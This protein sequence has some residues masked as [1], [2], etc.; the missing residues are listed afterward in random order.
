MLARLVTSLDPARVETIVISVSEPGPIGDYLE[1]QGV[2]V[3]A[4][5]LRQGVPDVRTPFRVVR[6]LRRWRADL[7][8]TWLYH[9]DIVGGMAGWASRIP[10][11]WNVRQTD[12]SP[13]TTRLITR[14]AA[15]AAAQW[16]SWLAR[17]I[18]CVSYATR[19]AHAAIGYDAAKME[20][21]PNGFDLDVCKPDDAARRTVRREFGLPAS[22]T[23][24]GHV[25]RY[26]PA[27]DHATM[28]RAAAALPPSVH[29]MMVGTG[30]TPDNRE[31]AAMR[32]ALG[33]EQRV[34]LIG[35]RSDVP[36]LT[37]AFDVAV[38]SSISEGFSNAIGEA[39]A[40]GVPCVVTDVGDSAR[41][42][43]D[44]GRVVQAGD[45]AQLAGAIGDLLA[46]P[47]AQRQRLGRRARERI[48]DRYGLDVITA[49]Y[50]ALW[51][52]VC[53]VAH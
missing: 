46:L 20:V 41:I 39:M 26:D 5:G 38:S 52:R 16:S 36:R 15:H 24:V 31:L 22:A 25:G 12:L 33:L 27:K 40:C 34:H 48:E 7:L 53:A 49:R 9:A 32:S 42:V 8:Q 30:V 51:R 43:G 1:S 18:V 44:T 29:V 11:V 4:L 17:A 37:A 45:A 13:R 19:D 28:L 35:P 47:E 3:V 14:V 6:L 50:V 2:Q 23:L 21:I 10:V